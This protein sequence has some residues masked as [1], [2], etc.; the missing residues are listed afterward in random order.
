MIRAIVENDLRD[1]AVIHKKC[2]GDHF[3]SH[4]C[5]D[6][7]SFLLQRFYK[8][9]KDLNPDYFIL[10][11]EAGTINGFCVGYRMSRSNFM[12]NFIR[13]NRIKVGLN[14]LRLLLS[15]DK[16]AWKKVKRQFVKSSRPKFEVIN[17]QYDY[18]PQN[19]TADLLSI[20]VLPEY[21]G[22]GYAKQL[23]EE[24]LNILK[25]SG[26]K[27]CLLSVANENDSAKGLYEKCGFIPYRKIGDEGMTYMKLL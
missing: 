6:R 11:E 2:F 24:Y 18:I 26:M 1:I 19:E 20:C 21:R 12:E 25:V 10:S 17:H 7:D 22:K 16:V 9:L 5:T 15:F 3:A 14:T 27:L 4:L 8:E 13:N 23:I